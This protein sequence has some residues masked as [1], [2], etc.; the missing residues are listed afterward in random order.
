MSSCLSLTDDYENPKQ[1]TEANGRWNFI[2]RKGHLLYDGAIVFRFASYNIP[3][4]L[5]LEDRVYASDTLY[6]FPICKMPVKNPEYDENGYGYG[7]ENGKSCIIQ[8]NGECDPV[9]EKWIIPTPWE[10]EDAIMSIAGSGGQVA[11]TYTLGFGKNYHVISPGT[12][13]EEAFVAMDHAI[14]LARKHRIRL[15]IP[16]INNHDG[17]DCA[18]LGNFGD[19]LSMCNSRNQPPSQFYRNQL[20][21]ADLKD[22]ITYVLKRIN[23]VNGIPYNSDPTILAWQI[24]NELGGWDG[25]SPPVDWTIEMASHIKSLAPNTLVMDGTMGGKDA[26]KKFNSEILKSP[27]LDIFSL[28]YYFGKSDLSRLS[29]DSKF[30]TNHQKCFIIG[31]FGFD[32]SNCQNIFEASLKNRLVSGCLIWSLRFHSRDGGFYIHHED[33]GHCSFHVPGFE[34][35]QGFGIDDLRMGLLVR[36]YGY[37]MQG[38]DPKM[39][40]YFQPNSP[41]LIPNL[42]LYPTKLKWRGSAWAL[43]YR[44]FRRSCETEWKFVIEVSDGIEAG[45]FE[46]CDSNIIKGERYY[47]RIEPIAVDGKPCI[48]HALEFGPLSLEIDHL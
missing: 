47:Y 48:D 18:R 45:K 39:I 15:I 8:K 30:V 36:E 16:F 46:Y 34:L 4:L 26:T 11:R 27:F 22:I 5:M 9:N 29:R 33:G 32:Y 41:S 40:S 23:T 44:L 3:N 6:G 35:S 43:K 19:Y 7:Q 1:P 25:E 14:A 20:L 17:G 38:F 21:R 31:E 10:Q 2:T 13:N 37:K 28:H 12:Y 24:G 42:R